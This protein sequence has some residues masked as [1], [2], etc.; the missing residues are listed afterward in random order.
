ML[1]KR[2]AMGVEVDVADD[3]DEDDEEEA[4]EIEEGDEDE[5]LKLSDLGNR[6]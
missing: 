3:V 5:K 1:V 4:D 2:L 6:S